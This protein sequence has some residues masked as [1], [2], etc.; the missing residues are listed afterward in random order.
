[1]NRPRLLA[2][3]LV[4]PLLHACGFVRTH[5]VPPFVPDPSLQDGGTCN[6]VPARFILGKS[7]DERIAE[8]AR[9][10]SGA[11]V[12]RVLRPGVDHDDEQRGSRL[13]LVTDQQG[14]VVEVRCG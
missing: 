6:D 4:L 9:V 10:R 13:D 2:A 3:M 14:Q 7:V 12:V 1:M 5:S 8:E 11:R